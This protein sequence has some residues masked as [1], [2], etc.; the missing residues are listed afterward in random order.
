MNI[1]IKDIVWNRVTNCFCAHKR[2]IHGVYLSPNIHKITFEWGHKQFV[3]R[4]YTFFRTRHKES[5]HDDKSEYFH[6][7]T[8]FLF[9]LTWS[10]FCYNVTID[11]RWRHRCIKGDN[12]CDA[13]TRKEISSSLEIN[14]THGHIHGRSCKNILSHLVS[15]QKNL[16][17]KYGVTGNRNA[18]FLHGK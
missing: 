15:F 13:R 11:C 2:N 4:V 17:L 7:S 12:N 8:P 9:S 3:T 18:P 6:T 10:T 1:N 16:F 14:F 5:I